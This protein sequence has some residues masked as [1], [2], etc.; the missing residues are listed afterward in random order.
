MNANND[1]RPV[2]D[3]RL[4][5]DERP[6]HPGRVLARLARQVE[7]ALT[8]ADLTLPQYRVLILLCERTEEASVLAYKLAVSRPSVTG[9][10]DGLV[11]RG[12]VQRQH[13]PADRRRV[14]HW[15]TT[16]GRRLLAD[17]D[18][19]VEQRLR[20]IAELR[21]GEGGDAFAELASWQEALDAYRIRWA[22]TRQAAAA[23]TG[24]MPV[25][26]AP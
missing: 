12:A 13:D 23:T 1:E 3:E 8:T 20:Q 19:E 14:C 26:T 6:E 16:D 22:R 4:S 21:P 11:A 7:L 2:D 15:L 24:T 17:A 18:A 9:V 25:R 5:S 10:V